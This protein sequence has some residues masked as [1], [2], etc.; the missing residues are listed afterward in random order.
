VIR[1]GY[2]AMWQGAEYEASPDGTDV[3][4]YS[5]GAEDGFAEIGPGR[6]RR[7]VAAGDVEW[8]GYVRTIA[9]WGEVPVHILAEHG[10]QWLLAVT[11]RPQPVGFTAA[12]RGVFLGWRPHAEV[13]E[14]EESR[15][16]AG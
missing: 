4:L 14:V 9:R 7:I 13:T 8:F 1:D 2:L 6:Y 15:T 3:R 11:D 10:G 16:P 12:E 5:A